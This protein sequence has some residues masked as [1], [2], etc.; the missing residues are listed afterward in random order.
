MCTGRFFGGSDGILYIMSFTPKLVQI[1]R[2]NEQKSAVQRYR[3]VLLAMTAMVLMSFAASNVWSLLWQQSEWLTSTILPAVVVDLTNTQRQAVQAE[4]LVRNPSLDRAAQLKAEHMAQYQYFAHYSPDGVTPWH[5]FSEAGY[6]FA[7][8][9]EN[10]A[11]HFTDSRA[12]V[13]AWIDSPTHRANIENKN[14]TEIGIGVARGRFSGYDTTFVVQMFGT[15]ALAQ[16]VTA[17]EPLMITSSGLEDEEQEEMTISVQSELS[18]QAENQP[19]QVAGVATDDDLSEE[20]ASTSLNENQE[21]TEIVSLQLEG[22]SLE[23]VTRNEV[24][25]SDTAVT[26]NQMVDETSRFYTSFHATSSELEPATTTFSGEVGGST[27]ILG[28]IATQPSA[29]LQIAYLLFAVMTFMLI[30]WSVFIELNRRHFI[31]VAFSFALLLA[32]AGLW[33]VHSMAVG[34][35]VLAI[36]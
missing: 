26:E 12:L 23:E 24:V 11:V 35:P 3:T 19:L 10:L 25:Y 2:E 29:M 27:P 32:V 9:G 20:I 14:F 13:Q 1:Q 4:S 16:P 31:N 6:T 30:V 22:E 34:N 5:W 8:A 7:H 15:P 36:M 17:S 33:Y 18:N 28:R 21:V